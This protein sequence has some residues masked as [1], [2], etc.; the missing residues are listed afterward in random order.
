MLTEKDTGHEAW[1]ITAQTGDCIDYLDAG[2]RPIYIQPPFELP[3]GKG[4]QYSM[5]IP[6][7]VPEG[8]VVGKQLS[9]EVENKIR[10][11]F[12][13][14][15][16]LEIYPCECAVLFFPDRSAMLR[17]WEA[18]TPYSLG[19]LMVGYQVEWDRRPRVSR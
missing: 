1:V 19:G 7:P 12:P 16:G 14:S 17:T 6:D 5:T 9:K 8:L 11:A 2:G 10:S 3:L 18:G 13:E 4:R 15:V